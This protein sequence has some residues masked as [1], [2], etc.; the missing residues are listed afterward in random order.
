MD[1]DTETN[2]IRSIICWQTQQIFSQ[3][4]KWLYIVFGSRIPYTGKKRRGALQTWRNHSRL[5][6][7]ETLFLLNSRSKLLRLFNV[8][9]WHAVLSRNVL[10]MLSLSWLGYLKKIYLRFFL[11]DIF[12]I[13]HTWSDTKVLFLKSIEEFFSTSRI[14]T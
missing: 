5:F 2:D 9:W 7:S 6:Q 11:S 12:R 3:F 8:T 14:K 13:F 10:F 4:A 1:N